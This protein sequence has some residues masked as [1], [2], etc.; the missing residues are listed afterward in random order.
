MSKKRTIEFK[1]IALSDILEISLLEYT[2]W[3]DTY[4]NILPTE[5]IN[6]LNII[7]IQQKFVKR[8]SNENIETYLIKM[9]DI[10]VGYF[11]L[12]YY[13][14]ALELSKIYLLHDY[15]H[16]GIG[17]YTMYFVENKAL[18]KN[19]NIIESWI[20]ENNVK[21][22]SFHQKM[23]FRPSFEQKKL[24]VD[25]IYAFKYIKTLTSTDNQIK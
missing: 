14:E 4:K 24:S 9:N 5:Y 18:E 12:T 19:I 13:K 16:L 15:H 22:V 3:R 10:A 17:T 7:H 20:I 1:S 6:D 21:S 8:L 23:G 25:N 2:I 11:V